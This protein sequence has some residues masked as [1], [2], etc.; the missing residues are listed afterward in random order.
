MPILVEFLQGKDLFAHEFHLGLDFLPAFLFETLNAQPKQTPGG[1]LF[2]R[3][4]GRPI[5]ALEAAGQDHFFL[6]KAGKLL[7]SAVDNNA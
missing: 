4:V 6:F 7:P 5:N 3:R 1:G 2:L